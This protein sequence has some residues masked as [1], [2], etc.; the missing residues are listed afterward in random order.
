MGTRY[1][2]AEAC[3]TV[4]GNYILYVSSILIPTQLDESY[5]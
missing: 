4:C 1:N 5:I 3:I 2:I